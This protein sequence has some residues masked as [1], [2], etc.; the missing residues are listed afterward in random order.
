MFLGR[1]WCSLTHGNHYGVRRHLLSITD[2]FLFYGFDCRAVSQRDSASKPR[3][4]MR[5]ERLPWVSCTNSDNPKVGCGSEFRPETPSVT[6]D[7]SDE[8][9]MEKHREPHCG[10]LPVELRRYPTIDS[11][12]WIFIRVI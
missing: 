6:T 1:K 2:T 8:T 12:T 9:R 11:G 10:H 3:V 7:F 4:G 5:H